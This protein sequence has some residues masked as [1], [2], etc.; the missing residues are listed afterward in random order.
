VRGE[1]TGPSPERRAG[2]GLAVLAVAPA[3]VV[4]AAAVLPR[5]AIGRGAAALLPGRAAGVAAVRGAVGLGA[6][7]PTAAGPG[8]G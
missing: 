4:L 5:G 7:E 8:L 6:P 1:G 3:G 2:A